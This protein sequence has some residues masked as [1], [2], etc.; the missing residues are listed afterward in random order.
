MAESRQQRR[1]LKKLKI[2]A[3]ELR[4]G[5]NSPIGYLSR[6]YVQRF[7]KK[8][9]ELAKKNIR[10]IYKRKLKDL[11]LGEEMKQVQV[12]TNLSNYNL[13]DIERKLLNKGLKF[14]IFL[15]KLNLTNIQT[16]FEDFYQQIRPNLSDNKHRLKLKSKLMAWFSKLKST[17]FYGLKYQNISLSREERNA[18][19]K[20]ESNPTLIIY[21]PDKGNGVVVMNKDDYIS[22]I[23]K[24]LFNKTQFQKVSV[25]DNIVNL[26]KFQRFQY[27][28]NRKQF[29]EK[30]VYDRIRPISALTPTLQGLPKLHKEGYP[31]R[32]ILASNGCYTY[33]CAVW[34]NEI[35][36]PLREH[37]SCIKD[38]L[39]FVSRLSKF[40]FDSSH[41]V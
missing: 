2:I 38:T 27:N 4:K 25:D 13:S 3:E 26:T 41:I 40:N 24:I 19:Q 18:L 10:I 22:K 8:K 16:E 39:D 28:L 12:L 20:L 6:I 5:L 17:F 14:G 1:A 32:P 35:P 21:I 23:N 9:T 36:S 31:C 7:I 11:G 34:L 15:D 29:L 37:P 33:D 30:E